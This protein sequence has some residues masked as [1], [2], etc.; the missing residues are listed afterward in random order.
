MS[1]K[2]KKQNMNLSPKISFLN[3]SVLKKKKAFSFRESRKNFQQMV[4]RHGICHNTA[5]LSQRMKQ[6]K[7]TRDGTIK[8]FVMATEVAS[9]NS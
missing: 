1:G 9:R 4:Q 5:F 2:R 8:T 7:T 6:I 3:C